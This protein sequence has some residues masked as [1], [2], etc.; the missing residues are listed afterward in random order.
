MS[1]TKDY[2]L[3]VKLTVKGLTQE[4]VEVETGTAL[5]WTLEV[6]DASIGA[7]QFDD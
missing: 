6:E 2:V 3:D 4:Q 1:A 7:E 5:K